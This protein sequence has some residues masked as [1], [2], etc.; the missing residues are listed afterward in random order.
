[1]RR[2]ANR[3]GLLTKAELGSRLGSLINEGDNDGD[4]AIS[5]AELTLVM[6]ARLAPEEEE[7]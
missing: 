6:Q 3:D 5:Y 4:G 7:K 1:M 2:D